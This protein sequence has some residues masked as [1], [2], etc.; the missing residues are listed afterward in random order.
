MNAMGVI[1]R[2]DRGTADDV[3]TDSPQNME[4]SWVMKQPVWAGVAAQVKENVSQRGMSFSF[5]K[6]CHGRQKG[7]FFKVC[8]RTKREALVPL[9]ASNHHF[10]IE[11][12]RWDNTPHE[13]MYGCQEL[14]DEEYALY[15]LRSLF[16]ASPSAGRVFAGTCCVHTMTKLLTFSC[17]LEP[18]LKPPWNTWKSTLELWKICFFRC[19]RMRAV[20]FITNFNCCLFNGAHW[21]PS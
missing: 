12:G 7:R 5:S 4:V 19:H 8:H 14:D 16:Y 13:R 9:L 18:T 21:M 2:I 6:L 17:S 3:L 10:P 1:L 20:C 11:T 15:F